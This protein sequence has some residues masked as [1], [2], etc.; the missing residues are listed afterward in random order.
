MIPFVFKSI[1]NL[2]QSIADLLDHLDINHPHEID[3]D[4]IAKSRNIDIIRTSVK[5]SWVASHPLKANWF[6]INVNEDLDKYQQ[7]EVIAHE[8][9]HCLFHSGNQ[10]LLPRSVIQ[11]QE[12][13]AKLGATFLLIP[14]SMLNRLRQPFHRVSQISEIFRVAPSLVKKRLML[15]KHSFIEEQYDKQW[16]VMFT[17]SN[18][19][20]NQE[21][22]TY[23][24]TC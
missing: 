1:E 6:C 15:H 24:R 23:A 18:S 21:D 20:V 8:L 9:I 17:S 3:L 16:S 5:R 10:L 19:M 14:S 11:H 22:Q 7:R 12:R 2:E 4:F 13:E